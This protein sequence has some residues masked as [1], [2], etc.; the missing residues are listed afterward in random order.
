LHDGVVTQILRMPMEAVDTNLAE[1]WLL[2]VMAEEVRR[3]DA[4]WIHDNVPA[5]AESQE[6]QDYRSAVLRQDWRWAD[7]NTT[8]RFLRAA[9]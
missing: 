9:S 1:H 8:A 4:D 3:F 6:S 2:V 7:I 5:D